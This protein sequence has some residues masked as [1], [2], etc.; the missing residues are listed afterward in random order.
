MPTGGLAQ[1][2][3]PASVEKGRIEKQKDVFE[4]PERFLGA[5]IEHKVH[6]EKHREES[7]AECQRAAQDR[8]IGGDDVAQQPTEVNEHRGGKTHDPDSLP[9][10]QGT[11]AQHADI[12]DDK[13]GEQGNVIPFSI[14]QE[15][16]RQKSTQR[17]NEGDFLPVVSHGEKYPDARYATHQGKSG[18]LPEELVLM[19]GNGY[20]KIK[21]RQPAAQQDR[22][23][24]LVG[25]PQVMRQPE[26][27][28]P[29]QNTDH[30]ASDGA[31]PILVDGIFY[32][33]PN[34]NDQDA[35]PDFVQ[36]VAANEFLQFCIV[37]GRLGLGFRRGWAG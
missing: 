22:A 6:G 13:I 21:D 4:C 3:Q 18:G 9:I 25:L 8:V 1:D 5:G 23:E 10:P 7:D 32:K 31:D 2:G 34:P 11:Q 17:T 12:E 36:Q 37:A 15:E 35:D 19:E 29:T 28:S 24:C 20:R 26:Q 33:N 27:D 16:G 30:H 14:D